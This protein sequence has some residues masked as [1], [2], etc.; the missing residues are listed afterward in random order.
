MSF[1]FR[2]VD[3][4]T[5]NGE[6]FLESKA[7]GDQILSVLM[8]VQNLMA[9]IRRED[10]VAV[11]YYGFHGKT[12]AMLNKL[13]LPA[14]GPSDAECIPG[15]FQP[16]DGKGGNILSAGFLPPGAP[17]CTLDEDCPWYWTKSDSDQDRPN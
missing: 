16:L 11:D 3:L 2:V 4:R 7:V 8:R 13:G 17:P 14:T 5:L 12:R 9:A 6:R 1:R 15:R 10:C